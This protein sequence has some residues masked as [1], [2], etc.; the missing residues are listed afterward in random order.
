VARVVVTGAGGFLGRG[1][2][3][4]L[5][6]AGWEVVALDHRRADVTDPAA[7]R[8]RVPAADAVVHLAFPTRMRRER[9]FET[10]QEVLAGTSNV[11]RLAVECGAAQV[12]LASSGKVY[13]P[14][15]ALPISEDHPL[16]PATRLGALKRL[17]ESVLHLGARAV[18]GAEGLGVTTLRIFNVYGP[19]QRED[20]VVPYLVASLRAGGPLRL[21]E[22]D[23]RRDFIHLDD[24]CAAFGAA[25]DHPAP[26][27]DLRALNV[28]TGRT[29]TV[30]ELVERLGLL[31][32]VTPE[33]VQD[34]TRRRPG[35]PVEERADV[36]R[37]RALGWEPRVDLAEGLAALWEGRERQP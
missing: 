36:G 7:L 35:E 25:L 37:L 32:G 20:F 27:G 13:G 12:V 1:V 9:P 21:G 18:G 2:C 14:P 15:Q 10:L 23:H 31:A 5:A 4:R 8:G 29:A 33:V 3:R 24:A 17:A 30:R 26:A 6:G 16:A 19:G 22:L 28:G 34:P 11:L